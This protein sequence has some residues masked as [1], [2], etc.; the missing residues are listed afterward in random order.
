MLEEILTPS[1]LAI[2]INGVRMAESM[3]KAV[4]SVVVRGSMGFPTVSE[5]ELTEA[6]EEIPLAVNVGDAVSVDLKT[7]ASLAR[8]FEGT[9]S[10][11]EAI[12]GAD[13][14]QS[15]RIRAYDQLEKLRQRAQIRRVE[16][17]SLASVAGELASEI[18]LQADTSQCTGASR[19]EVQQGVSDL[20]FLRRLAEKE[21]LY[22]FVRAG[23]LQLRGLG[24]SEDETP[25]KLGESLFEVQLSVSAEQSVASAVVGSWNAESLDAHS[26]CEERTAVAGAV[27]RVIANA[28]VDSELVSRQIGEYAVDRGE[29]FERVAKGVALGNADL[30]PGRAVHIGGVRE[31]FA[32]RYVVN[33]VVHR[34]DS[35]GYRTEF[36]TEPPRVMETRDQPIVTPGRVVSIDDPENRGRCRVSV[37]GFSEVEGGWLQAVIAGAGRRKGAAIL[38]EV[39]EDVLAVFPNGDLATGFVLGGLYGTRRLP[40]GMDRDSDRPYVVRTG[41]GQ[42]LE[43]SGKGALARVSTSSGSLLE[44]GRNRARLASATDLV[45]EAPGKRIV[46][47]ADAIDFE[48]G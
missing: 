17:A 34:L 24:G 35:G 23:I 1:A 36:N 11:V 43:L 5:I 41:G 7:Q 37:T 39:G 12:H 19:T 27:D 28:A 10:R 4:S 26:V 6:V 47:R 13:G 29:A 20:E 40:S 45:I 33:S 8:L 31:G 38:P 15:I 22:P 21:G 2:D 9:V 32:G 14:M 18:G 30:V 3:S 25:L 44:F 16:N 46:I 48:R 42:C